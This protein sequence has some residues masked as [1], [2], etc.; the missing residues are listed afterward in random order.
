MI[1]GG[2]VFTRFGL[3]ALAGALQACGPGKPTAPQLT[4]AE[5]CLQTVDPAAGL[6]ACKAAITTDQNNPAFRRRV[7][8]LRLKSHELAAARQAYQVAISMS[9]AYDAEAQFGL[10]LTL[11]AIGEP[12]ANLKKLEAVQHDPTVVD[13]FRKYGVSDVDL[14]TFDTA[15]EIVGGQ[16][17]SADKSM[18]PKQPLPQ[19]LTVDVRCQAALDGKLHDCIVTSPIKPDQAAFGEAAKAILATTKVRPAR[20]K[21]APVADAPIVLTYVFWPQS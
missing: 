10:G 5:A 8:L 20:N 15:P 13:K 9:S 17:P 11:E 7:G 3:M 2:K 6:D 1:Q 19:G 16:S 18:I 14:M 21:G 4:P 12:K